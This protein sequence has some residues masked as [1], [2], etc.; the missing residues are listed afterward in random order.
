MPLNRH[1]HSWPSRFQKLLVYLCSMNYLAHAYLSFNQ[2][3]IL[4][5]NMISDFVKGKKKFDY[6]S[7]IQKG[8][9]LHRAIDEF[10]D[11]AAVT[12]QAKIFFKPHYG[13]YAGAFMDIVYDHF[14]AN[15]THEFDEQALKSF[16]QHTYAL[17]EADENIFPENFKRAFVHMKSENWLFNYRNKETIYKSFYGLVRR[18]SFMHEHQTAVAVFE[19]HYEELK[20]CYQEFFPSVRY[21]AFEK[22]QEL[23]AQ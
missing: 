20:A 11:T 9:T 5:G 13:L 15:D 6:S 18:A 8:I 3:G 7:S 14:L 4:S 22:L 16:S 21:F 2:P 1:G 23:L 19:K 10:T 17:L 12:K